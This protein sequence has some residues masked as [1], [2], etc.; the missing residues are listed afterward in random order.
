MKRLK[1][2]LSIILTMSIL[3]SCIPMQV[4]ASDSGEVCAASTYRDGASLLEVKKDRAPL[5]SGPAEKNSI[6]IRCDKGVV[7]EKKDTTINKYLNKWYKVTYKDISSGSCY[8]GY[9]YSENVEKHSHSFQKFEHDGV[10]YK[11]SI[12]KKEK[13]V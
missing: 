10:T 9:I 2:L 7:L 13:S 12:N 4:F 8:S 3:L 5:R 11:Y 1:R 6:L